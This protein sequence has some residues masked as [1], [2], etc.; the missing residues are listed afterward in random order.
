M[1]LKN[2]P[3]L[4]SASQESAAATAERKSP[5]LLPSL[6]SSLKLGERTFSKE[7]ENEV[8]EEV[9]VEEVDG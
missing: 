7:V 9:G 5:D 3:H 2:V 4:S 6:I 1:F 8:E